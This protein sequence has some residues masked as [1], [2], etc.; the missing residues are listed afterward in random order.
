MLKPNGRFYLFDVV[1]SFDVAQCESAAH[2]FIERM[3]VHMG[4]NG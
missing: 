2:Q 3:S 4:P 1:F